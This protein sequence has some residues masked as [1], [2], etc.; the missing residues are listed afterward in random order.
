MKIIIDEEFGYRYWLWDVDASFDDIY[1]IVSEKLLDPEF[2]ATN[3][4][5]Q[6]PYGYWTSMEFDEY[7][8]MVD[9]DD[10]DAYG[11]LHTHDDSY[12]ERI[13]D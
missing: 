5:E 3:L 2:F 10:Y 6:F 1:D 7:R 9:N 4:P 11:H 13:K 12:L 8:K